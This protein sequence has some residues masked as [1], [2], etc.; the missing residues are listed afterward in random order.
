MILT[1]FGC[2]DCSRLIRSHSGSRI[3]GVILDLP[4]MAAGGAAGSVSREPVALRRSDRAPLY[5]EKRKR[6]PSYNEKE[7]FYRARVLRRARKMAAVG[8][9]NCLLLVRKRNSGG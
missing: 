4:I 2:E 8:N 7:Y 6:I 9:V 1:R 3:R 5:N